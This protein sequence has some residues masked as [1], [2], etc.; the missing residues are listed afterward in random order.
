MGT[1]QLMKFILNQLR[2]ELI[3]TTQQSLSFLYWVISFTVIPSLTKT[4][5]SLSQQTLLSLTGSQDERVQ[6]A[7]AGCIKNMRV[8]TINILAN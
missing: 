3:I 7:A 2:L 6:E 4:F 1:C 5:K 8:N